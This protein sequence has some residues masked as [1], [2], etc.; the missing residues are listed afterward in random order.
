M[1]KGPASHALRAT[2]TMRV[3]APPNE[4]ALEVSL[5]LDAGVLVLFGPSGAGK[6]LTL[7]GLA[8][9]VA[10]AEGRVQVGDETMLDTA[11]GVSVPPHARRIGYVPQGAALFPFLD[12]ASNV[13]FGLP[14]AARPHDARPW[15]DALGVAHLATAMPASLSFGERQRVALARALAVRPKLLLLD[16][17]FASVDED[18]TESLRELVR[19]TV[20]TRGVPVVLVTHDKADAAA[21]GDRLVRFVRGRT[22]ASGSVEEMLR[23]STDAARS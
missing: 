5:E 17:P 13:T 9:L 20:S 19:E 22:V 16:E 18:G 21:L 10:V 23:S 2:F 11:H 1:T 15:L 3:G 4:F 12:V 6:T 8:G 7:K 14:R